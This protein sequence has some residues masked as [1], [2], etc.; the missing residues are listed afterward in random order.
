MS[1]NGRIRRLERR[2]EASACGWRDL[3]RQ[4]GYDPVALE[5]IF[6][7]ILAEGARIMDERPGA[8]LEE[9]MADAGVQARLNEAGAAALARLDPKPIPSWAS[10]QDAYKRIA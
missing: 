5:P 6:Q 2:G 1:L 7:A 8:G 9:L 10:A 4:L 3:A